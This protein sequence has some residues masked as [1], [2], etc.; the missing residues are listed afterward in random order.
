MD[1]ISLRDKQINL[2]GTPRIKTSLD[3][4]MIPLSLKAFFINSTVIAPVYFGHLI[5]KL[6]LCF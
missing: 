2:N 3:E 5:P 1:S 6:I 4:V